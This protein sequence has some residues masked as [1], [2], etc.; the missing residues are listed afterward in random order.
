MA[1]TILRKQG[2]LDN[3]VERQKQNSIGGVLLLDESTNYLERATEKAILELMKSEIS[4]YTIITLAGLHLLDTISDC[5][6]IAILDG[7]RLVQFDAPAALLGRET[8]FKKSSILP[9]ELL[10]ESPR[11]T[12]IDSKS[13][14]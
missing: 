5:D 11:G 13:Q 2:A 9:F 8:V 4:R 10:V 3:A 14:G 6:R 12:V 1:W 7:G